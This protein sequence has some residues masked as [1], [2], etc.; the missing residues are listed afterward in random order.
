MPTKARE[1]RL[2]F[3]E[4]VPK[5]CK[6]GPLGL[7]KPLSNSK[8]LK[9]WINLKGFETIGRKSIRFLKLCQKDLNGHFGD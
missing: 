4:I 8:I 2:V 7:L 3:F 6:G 1:N 5:L 9:N